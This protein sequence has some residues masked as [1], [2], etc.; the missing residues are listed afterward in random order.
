MGTV[1]MIVDGYPI[2]FFYTVKDTIKLYDII[3]NF[4]L[5]EVLNELINIDVEKNEPEE[6]LNDI[7]TIYFDN[8]ILEKSYRM[9][10][11]NKLKCIPLHM[12]IGPL[13]GCVRPAFLD[14]VDKKIKELIKLN[15]ISP[16]IQISKNLVYIIHSEKNIYVAL[17]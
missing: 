11:S 3:R 5:N 12:S 14:I 4:K 10:I 16:M 2:N 7:Y 15:M 8:F 13:L 6:E 17:R 1:N 9:R